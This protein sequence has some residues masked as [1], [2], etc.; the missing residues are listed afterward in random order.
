M[1]IAGKGRR[2]KP[3]LL[4]QVFCGRYVNEHMVTH[5]VSSEHLLVLSCCDLSVWCYGCEAYV[6]NEV[7]VHHQPRSHARGQ[8]VGL[9]RELIRN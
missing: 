6:H 4:S 5:S 3:A 1:G 2:C 7:R 8:W 9:V